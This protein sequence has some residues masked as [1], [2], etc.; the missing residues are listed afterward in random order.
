MEK[1]FAMVGVKNNVKI[2][3]MIGKFMIAVKSA[4][5]IN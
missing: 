4:H 2:L 3:V 5:Q 1:T